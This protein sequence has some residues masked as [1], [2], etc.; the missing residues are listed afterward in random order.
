MTRYLKKEVMPELCGILNINKPLG[1]SSHDVV[2]RVRRI[3]GQKKAGHAG[4][5]DPL[6]TGVLLLCLGQAT[7]VS[8]YLLGSDKVYRARMLLGIST[9]TYDTEGQVT[10]RAEV[11]VTR[12]Q[13]EEALRSFVGTLQQLPPMYSAVKHE[14]TPLYKLARRGLETEREA[15]AVEIK[16]M[17]LTGWEPPQVEVEVQ[18]SKGTY[19][20]SLAHELGQRLGCGA[21]LAA[22]TRTASGA[23]RLEQSVTL[24]EL[25]AAFARG[26]GPRLVLPMDAALRAFPAVALDPVAA[27]RVCQG[28]A[29]ELP[30]DPPAELCRAY[31]LDGRL[32]ALLRRGAEGLWRPHKVFVGPSDDADHP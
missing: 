18:C 10:A 28:Q 25:D 12:E 13:V 30:A 32:L 2:W 31:A 1:I 5:L 9:D 22:L 21:H 29:V 7:R 20:R 23:F 8:E 19:V 15:R 11:N 6:A 26:E 17:T 24:E 27:A 3:T 4:T 16:A 14:G